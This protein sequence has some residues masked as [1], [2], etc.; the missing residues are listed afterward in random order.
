[1][2]ESLASNEVPFF[3]SSS[4]CILVEA[5]SFLET[6]LGYHLLPYDCCFWFF[7]V[8]RHGWCCKDTADGCIGMDMLLHD[9][10]AHGLTFLSPRTPHPLLA[11]ALLM[12]KKFYLSVYQSLALCVSV[13]HS[14][15]FVKMLVSL[16]SGC[17][18]LLLQDENQFRN[19]ICQITF[20]MASYAR[21]LN[22]LH[23]E[24]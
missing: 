22:M 5:Y 21:S 17:K 18:K 9:S 8:H 4:L 11:F 24:A 6:N 10:T 19:S 3:H 15:N 13:A 2:Q 20:C 23:Q 1:M 7:V 12:L 16:N 14:S